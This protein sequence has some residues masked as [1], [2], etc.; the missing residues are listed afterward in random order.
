MQCIKDIMQ[1]HLIH[2]H[3]ANNLLRLLFNSHFSRS[4][5]NTYILFDGWEGNITGYCT[6]VPPYFHEPQV[7]EN[8]VSQECNIQPYCLLAHQIID[9][10]D[11]SSTWKID[12]YCACAV[13][14]VVAAY[15]INKLQAAGLLLALD[16]TSTHI[17]LSTSGRKY[18][19][20]VNN[21][22]FIHIESC[23]QE[24]PSD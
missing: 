12:S 11:F 22:I 15:I 4:H 18:L 16:G 9:Y 24:E 2:V 8:T 1:N 13:Q 6:S 23:G 20:L 10:S 21:A 5:S 17:D 7:S 14:R 19:K 3:S